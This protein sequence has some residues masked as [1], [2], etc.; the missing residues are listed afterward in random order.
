MIRR[1]QRFAY[2]GFF[3]VW[4]TIIPACAPLIASYSLEAYK[5]ATTLKAETMALV[6]KSHEPYSRHAAEI[7][8]H[9]TKLAAAYEFAAGRPYN[10]LSARQWAILLDPDRAL[11]GGFVQ[12][13]QANSSVS[14]AFR[15]EFRGQIA[16]AFDL[17]ICLEANKQSLSACPAPT[18]GGS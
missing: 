17:I 6:G 12:F 11:Y 4:L 15:D 7:E 18:G 1:L 13:W 2:P 14:P 8:A 3:L 10:Q 5:N 16:E 9:S